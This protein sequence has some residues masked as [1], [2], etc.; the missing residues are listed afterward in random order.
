MLKALGYQTMEAFVE[1]TVPQHIRIPASVVS[2]EA[3]PSLT[4][5]EMIKRARELA[6]MNKAYRSFIGMGYHN[7]VV[8]KVIQRNVRRLYV[9]VD[10]SEA[11]SR[12]LPMHRSSKTQH[13]IPSTRLI[14]LKLLR[15]SLSPLSS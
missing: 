4:E 15:V 9:L 14:S 8:P 12:R 5:S 1:D 13:G 7:A 10:Y 6:N 11:H 2:N 3:I